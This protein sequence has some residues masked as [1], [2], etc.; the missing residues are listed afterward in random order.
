MWG[1]DEYMN[2]SKVKTRKEKVERQADFNE[3]VVD[4][5]LYNDD[6]E[7]NRYIER[8]TANEIPET[9]FDGIKWYMGKWGTPKR[10]DIKLIPDVDIGEL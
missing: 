3:F 7:E 2:K 6:G 8:A 5:T 10:I 1:D 9:V 4:V